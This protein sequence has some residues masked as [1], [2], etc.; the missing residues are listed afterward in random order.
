MESA[1]R[2]F[3]DSFKGTGLWREGAGN[4]FRRLQDKAEKSDRISVYF[5]AFSDRR[6]APVSSGCR[7]SVFLRRQ[8]MRRNRRNGFTLAE[9]LIVVAII[10][11]LTGIA[12]PVFTAQLEKSR[13]AADLSNVRSAVTAVVMAEITGDSSIQQEQGGAYAMNVAL[14]QKIEDWQSAK[15]LNIAGVSS[16]DTDHWL[17]KPDAEG[18]CLVKSVNGQVYLFWNG[19]ALGTVAGAGGYQRISFW[20][21]K[22]IDG[23]V[24]LYPDASSES[25]KK[26]T[27]NSVA[28]IVLNKGD[29][30]SVPKSV[31]NTGND[32][33][34]GVFAFYL[35]ENKLENDM[36]EAIVDS[37]W[38]DAADFESGFTAVKNYVG[39]DKADQ[40][41][42]SRIEGDRLIFTIESEDGL[43]LLVNNNNED[44]AETLLN[45][46]HI[47]RAG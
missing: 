40:Y 2:I 42:T 41:Y 19:S 47:H 7:A 39:D 4:G 33:P 8:R 43:T 10:G 26:Y 5:L 17:G 14:R 45:D 16:E 38:L 9:L 37:G 11:V 22:T 20:T 32:F 21:Q 1:Q 12:I 13:E 15:P 35:A 23:K 27:K 34:T 44:K 24:Y 28:P 29:T 31:K 25:V 30:I 18:T 36:Y 3:A 6:D 46:V